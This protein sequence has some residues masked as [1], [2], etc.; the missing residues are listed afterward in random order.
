M[1]PYPHSALKVTKSDFEQRIVEQLANDQ[2]LCDSRG[3]L[4]LSW[5]SC[6]AI[7]GSKSDF[8]TFNVSGKS[9]WVRQITQ[10]PE[11]FQWH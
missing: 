6:S 1:S 5:A 7:C 8:A 4:F 11:E 3:V 2:G 10:L 9:N